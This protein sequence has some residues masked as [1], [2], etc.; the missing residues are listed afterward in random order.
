MINIGICDDEIR[1]AEYLKERVERCVKKM[2]VEY[3]ISLYLSGGEVLEKADKL[4]ILFLDVEMPGMDGM[5]TGRQIKEQNPDCVIIMA[6]GNTERFTEAFKFRAYRYIVKPFDDE[7][8]E[9]VFV[10]YSARLIGRNKTEV[11]YNRRSYEILEREIYYI[12]A[13]NGYTLITANGIEYRS[14]LSLKDYEERLDTRIF[15]KISRSCLVNLLKV[16]K[17]T[18]GKFYLKDLPVKISRRNQKEFLQ[19]YI[20]VDTEYRN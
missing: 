7:E 11:F 5:E 16:E 18:D 6:T 13:Y 14:E 8:I 10:S 12:R 19:K 1:I 2:Q 4:D 3:E 15:F 9:E 20:K 17:R